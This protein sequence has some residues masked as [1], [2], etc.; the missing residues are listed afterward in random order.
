MNLKTIFVI[1]TIFACSLAFASYT[2]YDCQVSCADTGDLNLVTLGGFTF[3]KPISIDLA[4][5]NAPDGNV[6]Y[7]IC[8]QVIYRD[9]KIPRPMSDD[10][11]KK[12]FDTGTKL[13]LWLT[14]FIC[15]KYCGQEYESLLQSY[16]SGGVAQNINEDFP[17]YVADKIYCMDPNDCIDVN[18]VTVVINA[19]GAFRED[20][21]IE[22]SS[23]ES[24]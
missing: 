20:I 6:Q 24:E 5:T 11:L 21:E 8:C 23:E 17:E 18:A 19:E 2:D 10:E 15:D 12:V 1:S 22:K 3:A 7:S 9:N 16:I 13:N 4:P 14:G